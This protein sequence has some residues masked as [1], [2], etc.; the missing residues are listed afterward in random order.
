MSH[1]RNGLFMHHITLLFRF[2]I[3]SNA[4]ASYILNTFY[5]TELNN[6]IQTLLKYIKWLSFLYISNRNLKSK[7]SCRLLPFGDL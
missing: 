2:D 7:I 4:Y 3:A 1:L 5:I 6:I